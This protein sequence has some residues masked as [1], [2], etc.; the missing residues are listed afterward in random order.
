[1][2]GTYTI[3]TY[4]EECQKGQS[5]PEETIKK[6]RDTLEKWVDKA[7]KEGTPVQRVDGGHLLIFY[8]DGS[9]EHGEMLITY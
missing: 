7:K 9:I 1:M 8:P 4:L 6:V 3:E 5:Y 2:E